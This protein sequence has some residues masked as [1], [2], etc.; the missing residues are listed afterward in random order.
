MYYHVVRHQSNDRFLCVVENSTLNEIDGDDCASLVGTNGAVLFGTAFDHTQIRSWM[1]SL[2]YYINDTM[3]P[4]D[5]TTFDTGIS[6]YPDNEEILIIQNTSNHAVSIQLLNSANAPKDIVN[7]NTWNLYDDIW[8][9]V[10]NNNFDPKYIKLISRS[11]NFD[12]KNKSLYRPVRVNHIQ[13][14]KLFPRHPFHTPCMFCPKHHVTEM[15]TYNEK[16]L[17]NHG[18]MIE[19]ITTRIHNEHYQKEVI[20]SPGQS[21]ILDQIITQ[22][23]L[24]QSPID[25]LTLIPLWYKTKL[26]K[27]FNYSL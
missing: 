13:H 10:V 25:D 1:L 22:W 19:G 18:E 8:A 16:I 4:R 2:G 24:N 6:L 9:V 5:Y 15:K 20:L 21:I 3:P 26:R 17:P 23:K 27:H 7:W 11:I 12:A 14:Y